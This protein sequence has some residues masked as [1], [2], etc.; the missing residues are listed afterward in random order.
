MKVFV[1]NSTEALGRLEW[2]ATLSYP[3]PQKDYSFYSVYLQIWNP[4][5]ELYISST[6]VLRYLKSDKD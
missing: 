5:Y 6:C 3:G 2:E 1:T 4:L